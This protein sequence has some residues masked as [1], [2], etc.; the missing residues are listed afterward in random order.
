MG[1]LRAF[2][3]ERFRMKQ[4]GGPRSTRLFRVETKLAAVKSKGL[5]FRGFTDSLS[6]AD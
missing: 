3:G 1:V 5:Y 6:M 4:P 2:S